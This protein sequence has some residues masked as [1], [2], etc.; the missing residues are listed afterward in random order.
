MAEELNA[1]REQAAY[2]LLRFPELWGEYRW[3]RDG[4][5]MHLPEREPHTSWTEHEGAALAEFDVS[6]PGWLWL[7]AV[8]IVEK[9]LG[10]ESLYELERWRRANRQHGEVPSACAMWDYVVRRMVAV[11]EQLQRKSRGA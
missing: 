8:R 7:R 1:E 6:Y 9:S 11:H 4:F 5:L 10:P 2:F 3:R